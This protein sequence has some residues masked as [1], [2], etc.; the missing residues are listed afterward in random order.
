MSS[1]KARKG[2]EKFDHWQEQQEGSYAQFSVIYDKKDLDQTLRRA[3]QAILNPAHDPSEFVNTYVD[4]KGMKANQVNFSPNTVCLEIAAANLPELSFYDLPGAINSMSN[5]DDQYLVKFV[6]TLLKYYIQDENATV[7][8]ACAANQDV[9]TSTAIRFLTECRTPKGQKARERAL[10]VLTKPD[11][12]DVNVNK[13]TKMNDIL[14][15][16]EYPMGHGWFVTKQSSQ[17][18]LGQGITHDQARKA[19]SD[20]FATSPWA[21][22]LAAYQNRFGTPKL[23]NA[24]SDLLTRHILQEL[25]GI[26][27]RVKSRLNGVNQVLATFPAQDAAPTIAVIQEIDA[28]K[29]AL[30]AQLN[31]DNVSDFRTAYRRVYRD[32]QSGLAASQ[33]FVELTTPGRPPKP[34]VVALSSDEESPS[35]KSR[36]NES[37]EFSVAP[38]R[39]PVPTPATERRRKQVASTSA[40][41]ANITRVKFN[42]DE[43]KSSFDSAPGADMPGGT[44]NIVT[45]KLILDTLC[46]WQ[47]VTNDTLQTVRD[48]FDRMLDECV[49]S[50]LAARQGTDLFKEALKIVRALFKELLA[51]QTATIDYIVARELH[52]P[53]THAREPMKQ[54][55]AQHKSQLQARRLRHRVKEWYEDMDTAG[56]SRCTE[57]DAE[58]KLKDPN[59]SAWAL[60]KLGMLLSSAPDPDQGPL[61]PS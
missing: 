45:K 61:A 18:Q 20:F 5:E 60:E 22:E 53:I 17:K 19:E 14:G 16:T 46:G 43:V 25:P 1:I 30:L 37:R 2:G 48:A 12:V 55:T 44:S 10:G 47:L 36:P 4:P 38:S 7:L 23:Q 31:A 39:T 24:L 6:E 15:G 56:Y 35:K 9:E 58:K 11:L 26:V 29:T 41:A 54:K 33:P 34:D 32:L 57:V 49:S 13:I 3:Q 28:L 42:L 8:L 40:I 59:C 50:S 27:S 52:R 21:D 51:K